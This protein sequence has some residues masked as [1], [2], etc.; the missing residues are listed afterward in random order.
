MLSML[1]KLFA[2]LSRREKRDFFILQIF[3]FLTACAELFGTVSILPFMALAANPELIH[4]NEHIA[5]IHAVLGAPSSQ[6]FL[7][8]AGSLFASLV[9]LSNALT[10][11]SQFLMNRF[12]F[13][14]GREVSA[15]LFRYYLSKDLLFHTRT[16]S[17][18]LI[19]RTMRDSQTLSGSLFAS[20]L[21]LN[22]RIF[23][24]VLLS[25]LLFFISWQ[26]T[27]IIL[28]ILLSAY[29][30]VFMVLRRR[31]SA[32]SILK[33]ELDRKR[34]RWLNE[35]FEGIKDIKLYGAERMFSERY[36]AAT[37]EANRILSDNLLLGET[38]YYLIEAIVLCTVVCVTLYLINTSA[39]DVGS[40]LPTLTLFCMAGFKLFP[41]IQQ[42][43]NCITQFRAAQPVFNKLYP[44]I[45]AAQQPL[46]SHSTH[47]HPMPIKHSI[48]LRHINFSFPDS[49]EP[50]FQNLSANFHAGKIT[51]VIGASG[52]GK[53][54]LMDILMGLHKAE[55][56]DIYVDDRIITDDL[57]PEWQASVGYVPQ[58]VYLTDA[59]IAENI[60]FGLEL[61]D[62]D[63]N[64][65]IAA[66]RTAGLKE[67]IENLPKQ[68]LTSVG[69]RGCQLSGG[70]RQRIGIARAFYREVSVLI[71]DEATSALDNETQHR[72]LEGLKGI[73]PPKTIIMV[74]HRQETTAHADNIFITPTASSAH[75]R[76]Q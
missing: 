15:R 8:M 12:S 45:V 7:M 2:L 24:I 67:F 72:I 39:G 31:I 57:L 63:M 75:E 74:T 48:E 36:Y 69:E 28:A 44:D 66:A 47:L 11:L 21:R 3:M 40:A 41:K 73:H 62:I 26:I 19:Q 58:H 37:R 17:S 25:S 76:N 51:A 4:S 59:S 38:P 55:R 27:L 14:L 43:Y 9:I 71:L 35:G 18:S 16:N 6:H 53:S 49:R 54:T 65:V 32:N 33:K 46:R 34:T 68:Y 64:R 5:Y 52:A 29:A 22:G 50:L 10:L 70:Q 30:F 42:S 1:G 60:A 23:S 61:E 20:A 56:G 13:R